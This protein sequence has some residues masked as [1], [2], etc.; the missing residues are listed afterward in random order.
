MQRDEALRILQ[1]PT[2][3]PEN[4][5]IISE[6]FPEL[7]PL[8]AAHPA[9]YPQLE[10]WLSQLNE[11]EVDAALSARVAPPQTGSPQ[12]APAQMAP[13]QAVPAQALPAQV[14]S[15]PKPSVSPH[16]TAAPPST[17]KKRRGM[18]VA[19]AA[20][21]A[22][23]MVAVG[24][25]GL[26]WFFGRSEPTELGTPDAVAAG[27]RVAS[28]L[29]GGDE[30][31]TDQQVVGSPELF[32][33]RNAA[34]AL[35]VTDEG[36]P[37][38]TNQLLIDVSEDGGLDAA[39]AAASAI[40]AQVVGVNTFAGSYQL[41][42]GEEQSPE[43]LLSL[44]ATLEG[45]PHVDAASPNTLAEVSLPGLDEDQ[46][47]DA[48][49]WAYQ[50]SGA[51]AVREAQLE[52]DDVVVG[53]LD[54]FAQDTAEEDLPSALHFG[55]GSATPGLND[56]W[57]DHGRHASGT[58][59]T[60]DESDVGGIAANV[61]L[62]VASPHLMP[63]PGEGGDLLLTDTYSYL[64]SITFLVE[65]GAEILNISFDNGDSLAPSSGEEP[66]AEALDKALSP[67]DGP[68]PD[69]LVITA[70]K[71]PNDGAQ[72]FQLITVGAAENTGAD[73]DVIAPSAGGAAPSY[74][75][76]TAALVL[77]INPALSPT[78]VKTI[79]V[80][81]AWNLSADTPVVN[82]AAAT[83]IALVSKEED[84]TEAVQ[85]LE[86]GRYKT[87]ANNSIP[88]QLVGTWCPPDA[89]GP[90][91][92]AAKCLNLATLVENGK[93]EVKDEQAFTPQEEIDWPATASTIELADGDSEYSLTYYPPGVQWECLEGR[94]CSDD[95]AYPRLV[96]TYGDTETGGLEQGPLYTLNLAVPV[97]KW[98]EYKEMPL[99]DGEMPGEEGTF[100]PSPVPAAL[101][102]T[103]CTENSFEYYP[104]AEA[105]MTKC[106][107]FEQ[108]LEE[109]EGRH[110]RT[111][112]GDGDWG[113]PLREIPDPGKDGQF[114]TCDAG[115]P[116]MYCLHWYFMAAGVQRECAEPLAVS[117]SPSTPDGGGTSAL[118]C[119]GNYVSGE[120][121]RDRLRLSWDMRGWSVPDHMGPVYFRQE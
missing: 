92:P 86:D 101:R 43:E 58:I 38:L 53:V 66:L 6:G 61:T 23:L 48:Y 37:F 74:V 22:V 62:T 10:L 90:D 42:L 8:V 111:I 65:T 105:G 25:V 68:S 57:L 39:K 50:A 18:K 51:P 30:T 7:R 96:Q 55:S 36:L 85:R 115:A 113:E 78:D 1:D 5:A 94:E 46:T 118:P 21:V 121:N 15:T 120:E 60:L 31:I 24:A 69:V 41:L 56:L 106:I 104:A 27:Q 59:A 16:P 17:R 19:V 88:A 70:G 14:T 72:G 98:E 83:Q 119:I 87:S 45:Q 35:G 47:A 64:E 2:T 79:I 91:T 28:K 75:S 34:E 100:G 67:T 40:D 107:D 49:D 32:Y 103:W 95:V 29:V 93:V 26:F 77:G 82:A 54:V 116:N 44:A 11:P 108:W 63:F 80:E 114:I 9:L 109:N 112:A 99:V 71:T 81:T 97:S 73:A 4:L 102:G 89:T 33:Y 3:P 13:P 84:G 52:L 20:L 117:G 76:A 12:T 110:A